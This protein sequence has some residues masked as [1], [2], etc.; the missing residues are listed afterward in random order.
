LSEDFGPYHWGDDLGQIESAQQE[1]RQVIG[2]AL[3]DPTNWS[4][5]RRPSQAVRLRPGSEDALDPHDQ[6]DVRQT[7]LPL[8]IDLEVNDANTL[9]D[10][11]TWTLSATGG[12]TKVSDLTDVFPTRRY[13]RKPPKETAF[14]GGL[15]AGA[16][17]GGFGW[18]VPSGAVGSDESKTE[19][20]IQDTLPVRP[21]K[22]SVPVRIRLED[23]ILTA[24]PTA[25][26]ERRWTRH[27]VI[28]ERVA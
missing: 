8:G 3:A 27:T 5:R 7:Q 24:A 2:D 14:R 6:L 18:T 10:P 1:A 20:S 28:L 9:S 26:I 12:L 15:A 22:T 13:L 23:A 19:D 17:F 16:R 11:G 4:L 21:P 25:A